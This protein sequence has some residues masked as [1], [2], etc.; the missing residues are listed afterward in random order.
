MDYKIGFKVKPKEIRKNGIVI[1]TDGTNDLMPNE[2]SC[3]AYGYSYED[4]ICKAYTSSKITEKKQSSESTNTIGGTNTIKQ[5]TNSQ[6]IGKD[7]TIERSANSLIV[8]ESNEIESESN[9]AVVLGKMGKATHTG[10]FCI[11]GGGFNSEAG[12]LQYSVIQLSGKTTAA[13]D[14]RLY[15]DSD[16]DSTNQITLPANSVTTYEIFLSALCTG[17]ESGTAGDYEAYFFQ[18]V[19]RTTNDGT[20]AH[21]AKIDRLLGRTGNL[22]TEVIDTSSAYTLSV[23]VGGLANVNTQHHAVVKLHINK[24]NAVEI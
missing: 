2:L 15:I 5:S 22:G 7:N 10:E 23:I 14:T 13:S 4:G 8:G 21:N 1:F 11:G 24:T 17:G 9:N 18:G 12:L 19:V 16:V 3:V 6:T 20:M